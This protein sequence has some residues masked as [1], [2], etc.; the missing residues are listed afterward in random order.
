MWKKSTVNGHDVL[1]AA[2]IDDFLLACRD[3]PT[4]YNGVLGIGL[5]SPETGGDGNSAGSVD[6]GIGKRRMRATGPW[7]R[8][9]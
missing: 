6:V 1:L 8:V 4:S 2:H 7:E 5:D 9:L 3:R